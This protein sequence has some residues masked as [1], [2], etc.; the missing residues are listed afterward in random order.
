M[1]TLT[2]VLAGE[3]GLTFAQ[4]RKIAKFFN[5]GVL[6]FVE[7]EP[8]VEETLRSPQ[9]R[10]LTNQMPDLSPDLRSL[11]ERAERRRDIYLGLRDDLD[12]EDRGQYKPPNVTGLQLVQAASVAR[13]WLGLGEGWL[14]GRSLPKQ[15]AHPKKV[16]FASLFNGIALR[17]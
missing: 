13:K 6:F 10:T 7:K 8:V 12:P 14:T 9:F 5:R 1:K 2:E 15:L 16:C 3:A 11:I 4:L 17:S